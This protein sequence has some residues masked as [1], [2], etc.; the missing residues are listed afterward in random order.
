MAQQR[1]S[2]LRKLARRYGLLGGTKI[3]LVCVVLLLALGAYGVI[4]ASGASSFEIQTDEEPSQTVPEPEQA[5]QEVVQTVVVHVD[6]AVASPG[7]YVL[8]G[9]S[10][11][12]N[13]AIQMAEGLLPDA[14][15]TSMN[16]AAPI[17]D[18][19]KIHVPKEGEEASQ[20]ALNDYAYEQGV[21][22]EAQSQSNGRVNVNT[23]SIEELQ[24][25]PGVGE[26]TAAAI[27][28]EREKNGAFTSP[29]DLMR[30]S[31]IGEKKLQ[32]MRDM[33]DV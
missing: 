11:R 26:A 6:G 13:D 4:S 23:A 30:V 29:E 18:G 22:Q 28:E 17:T 14:D 9:K 7:V 10:L 32:K 33:V 27:I 25:L 12:V 31:G 5:V 21:Q 8:E 15:T 1:R 2:G 3:A 20:A 19:Q 16:L 24:N